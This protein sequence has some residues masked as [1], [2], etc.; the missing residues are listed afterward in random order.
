VFVRDT[1]LN[2]YQN[3]HLLKADIAGIDSFLYAGNVMAS[4]RAWCIVRVGKIFTKIQIESWNN[5]KWKGKSCQPLICRGGY[6]CRHHWRPTR[7]EWI[8]DI[9]KKT[10]SW[11][12]ENPD[13]LD[14]KLRQEIESESRK[15][16]A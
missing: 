15:L 4:S 11:Y 8:D 9:P 12:Q 3:I 16:N 2:Y 10:G 1:S 5:D 13:T 14:P 7:P 6:N